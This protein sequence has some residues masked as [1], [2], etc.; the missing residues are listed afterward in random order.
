[1]LCIRRE[2]VHKC[3]DQ[4]VEVAGNQKLTL[5]CCGRAGRIRTEQ[6]VQDFRR[7]TLQIG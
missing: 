6:S 7:V 1:V 2:Y 3:W 4:G 5:V